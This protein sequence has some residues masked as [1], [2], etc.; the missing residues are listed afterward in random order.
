[1]AQAHPDDAQR[2]PAAREQLKMLLEIVEGG[3]ASPRLAAAFRA[4][5]ASTTTTTTNATPSSSPSS[6]A[7]TEA[8]RALRTLPI[9]GY[10]PAYAAACSRIIDALRSGK[11][12]ESSTEVQEA[13]SELFDAGAKVEICGFAVTS[14]TSGAAR[15][16]FPQVREAMRRR[17]EFF[18]LREPLMAPRD[19]RLTLFVP[20]RPEIL[21]SPDGGCGRDNASGDRVLGPATAVIFHSWMGQLTKLLRAEGTDPA[22]DFDPVRHEQQSYPLALVTAENLSVEQRL[23][24]IWLCTLAK[25]GD[26]IALVVDTF[27]GSVLSAV[28]VLRTRGKEIAADLRAGRLVNDSLFASPSF[29]SSSPPS[30]TSSSAPPALAPEVRRAVDLYVGGEGGGEPRLEAAE[31][32]EEAL[33]LEREEGEAAAAGEKKKEAAAAGLLARLLP[34]LEVVSAIFTGSM[35]KYLAPMRALVCPLDAAVVTEFFGGSEGT[36]GINEALLLHWRCLG[37][38][39]GSEKSKSK[40]FPPLPEPQR[41]VALTGADVFMEFLPIDSSSASSSS[42]S[43]FSGGGGGRGMIDGK[44]V[45]NNG[46]RKEEKTTALSVADGPVPP[47]RYELVVTSFSGLAR[48]RVGDVVRVV[49]AFE[50]PLPESS[51]GGDGEGE[52]EGEGESGKSATERERRRAGAGKVELFR[53]APVFEFVGRAGSAL[54]LVWEKFD[55]GA[56]LAAV[57]ETAAAISSS[58]GGGGGGGGAGAPWRDFAARED[59][60]PAGGGAPSYVFYVESSD[61]D[62]QGAGASCPSLQSWANALEASLRSHNAVYEMLVVKRQISPVKVC[63]VSR[64]AFDSLRDAAVASGT[65]HAQY[66]TP[67]VVEADPRG[68]GRTGLLEARVAGTAQASV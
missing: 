57:A 44:E 28:R 5:K 51:E 36:Y 1:M 62:E 13:L 20:A 54:N 60:S 35:A 67:V 33:L 6:S 37:G 65:A 48:Y 29:S 11:E 32:L 53:G 52:G 14:G 19:C 41:F 59:L 42:S 40:P 61:S 38:Q 58:G 43:S 3:S 47:G 12:E 4:T 45:E 25:G 55:E 27:G 56:I 8:L 26:R 68:G 10:D 15:K 66:K 64:G 18:L 50:P 22:I 24:L 31:Q 30:A 9:S 17:N 16:L 46:G 23:Y 7:A 34:N 39:G 63:L 49:G 21:N 2:T